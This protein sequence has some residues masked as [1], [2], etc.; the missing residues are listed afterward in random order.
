MFNLRILAEI[1]YRSAEND[2]VYYIG[3]K[4]YLHDDTRIRI[5]SSIPASISMIQT[6]IKQKPSSALAEGNSGKN[7]RL[8]TKTENHE[9]I[10]LT[11]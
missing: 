6:I 4:L 9:K 8:Q 10:I 7:R 11:E 1:G 5:S 3:I 2:G